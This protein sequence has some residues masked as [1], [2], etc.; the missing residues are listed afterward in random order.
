M[1]SA[2]CCAYLRAYQPLDAFALSE[3]EGIER[4]LRHETTVR[5]V[6]RHS[7]GL[8]ARDERREAYAI[9]DDG[10]LLVCPSQTRL[11]TLLTLVAFERSLPGGAAQ[12]FFTAR[13]LEAARRELEAIRSRYPDRR[14]AMVQSAWRVPMQWFVCFDDVE[15]RMEHDGER[16]RILYRTAM[17]NARQRTQRALDVVKGGIVHPVIVGMVYELGAWLGTFDDRS[18]IELD[19]AS[20]SDLFEADELADDHSAADVWNAIEALG[21]RDG[22]R[23][24]LHYRRVNERWSGVRARETLN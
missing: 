3:R 23:A 2:I 1:G 13:E 24:G 14:P 19:Y 10:G 17:T 21:A 5:L 6:G 12:V 18:V 11:R 15:R 7:L 4:A 22:L 16:A 8:I 20:V 9:E